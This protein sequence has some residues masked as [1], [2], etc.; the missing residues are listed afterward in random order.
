MSATA[1]TAAPSALS[2]PI[3]RVEAFRVRVPLREAL[4]LFAGTPLT[5]R[6]FILVRAFAGP[7]VGTGF[8]FTRGA[9]VDRIAGQSIIPQ[10]VGQPIG[11]VRRIWNT[12]RQSVRFVSESGYFAR[13]FSAVD[14]ALWD[15]L[16]QALGVPL[17][18]LLGGAADRVP[19]VAIAGYYR[20]GD[21]IAPIRAEGERL[22]A[23]G[24]SMYKIPIGHDLALDV[25]RLR[26]FREVVGPDPWI[27]VDAH[28]GYDTIKQV[29]EVWRA[30]EPFGIAFL[31]DPFPS[32]A[33]EL[34]IQLAQGGPMRVAYGE[35]MAQPSIL[36][37]L[38]GLGG[39]DVVRPDATYLLGTTGYLQSV[40]PALENH[41]PVYPHYFPDLHAHLVGGLGGAW[42]EESPIEADTVNFHAL[43]A[44]QP[45]IEG[46]VWHLS[47]RPG[48]GI[49]WDEDAL[50]RFRVR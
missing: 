40:G 28:G 10:V 48:L 45:R 34:T 11:S 35:N 33:W 42:I 31:E 38:G 27:C 21:S 49:A 23:A 5:E 43:R 32:S 44:E 13:A 20:P 29:L 1:A 19:V 15:L 7:H 26:A 46:G 37:R 3:E 16:A 12:V 30:I 22:A 6:E 39:V 18:R 41:L 47:E 4:Q 14:N 17:W 36:H 2:L 8:G 24:Y 9:E 50:R 25:A